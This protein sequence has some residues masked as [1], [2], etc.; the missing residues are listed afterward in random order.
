MAAPAKNRNATRHGIRGYLAVGS[1][2]RGSSYVRRLLSGFRTS[3][4]SAVVDR[5]GE[6]GTYHAA[7]VQSACRHECRALLL[8]R[9]LRK[10]AGDRADGNGGKQSTMSLA[11]RLAVLRDISAASDSRDRCLEK[12]GLGK[13]EAKSWLDTFYSTGDDPA[14]ADLPASGTGQDDPPA[15]GPGIGTTC[16]PDGDNAPGDDSPLD[17][18]QAPSGDDLQAEPEAGQAENGGDAGAQGDK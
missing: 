10:E 8:T 2:P 17:A 1:L 16:R 12:L 11:D 15:D 6:I 9:W 5:H 4:E 3:L 13:Q 14:D 7:L 18:L